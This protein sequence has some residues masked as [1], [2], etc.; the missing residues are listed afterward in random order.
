MVIYFVLTENALF[1]PG[2]KIRVLGKNALFAP[3]VKIR[4]LE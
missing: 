2:V 1:A 3:G 4:V